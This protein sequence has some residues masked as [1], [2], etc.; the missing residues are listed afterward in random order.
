M[1]VVEYG[2]FLEV[3]KLR[4]RLEHADSEGMDDEDTLPNIDEFI[5]TLEDRRDWGFP[6]VSGYSVRSIV[7]GCCNSSCS[8]SECVCVVR[9]CVELWGEEGMEWRIKKKR[10]R[11]SII[12]QLMYKTLMITNPQEHSCIT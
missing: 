11:W 2:C 4:R 5:T 3:E 10:K 7:G 1:G 12:N 6:Y 9:M 8:V